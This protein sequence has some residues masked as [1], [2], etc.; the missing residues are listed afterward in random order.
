MRTLI[1][2]DKEKFTAT[3]G[4][5][6]V[7]VGRALSAGSFGKLAHPES[8]QK[9]TIAATIKPQ[10]RCALSVRCTELA[11][12]TF[13]TFEQPRSAIHFPGFR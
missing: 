2:P 4:V 1:R 7:A 13:Y 9:Y 6:T 10:L 3:F 11:K 8:T 12:I 5:V